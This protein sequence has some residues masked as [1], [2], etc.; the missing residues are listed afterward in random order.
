MGWTENQQLAIDTRDKSL[1]VSAAAGSGKTAI[2][3][4]RIVKIIV[5][6]KVDV[7]K[8]LVVTFTKAAAE[9]MRARLY[10]SL[11][12][13]IKNN[14][15]EYA[16]INKQ[17]SNLPS[18]SISTLHSFCLNITKRYFH[19]IN[20]DPGLGI[21]DDT[22]IAIL[23]DKA[24]EELFEGEYEKED[25]RFFHLLEMFNNRRD[26][27]Q[28]RTIIN[29]MHLFLKNRPFP[30]KWSDHA[31]KNF[32][33]TIEE[34][35]QSLFYKEFMHITEKKLQSAKNQLIIALKIA[36]T[37]EPNE[38]VLAIIDD[39]MSQVNN[40]INALR[41][42]YD[43]FYKCL[44]LSKFATLNFKCEDLDA[45][46]EIVVKRN[47][48]KDIVKKI[49]ESLQYNSP[50][51]MLSDIKD[52]APEISYLMDLVFQYD[53]IFRGLKLEKRLMDFNDIEHYTLQILQTEEVARELRN[54]YKFIFVDE[55]Q[56]SNE[57]QDTILSSMMKEDNVFFVGDVKQSIYRFRMADPTLF[58]EKQ[59]IF[60]QVDEH[61]KETI[62]L[63][64]NFRSRKKIIEFINLVFE[65]IMSKYIGEVDY[66]EE[67]KL[68]L[69]SIQPPLDEQVE[70]SIIY[71]DSDNISCDEV[72]EMN[73][74][75]A[76][77]I[78]IADKIK[79]LLR[80]MVYDQDIKEYRNITYKDIV[81]LLRTTRGWA[82]TYYETLNNEGIPVYAESQIG[83]FDTLEIGLVIQLI[84][85]IDNV[86][87]D[88]PLIGVMRS[89]IFLFTIEEITTIRIYDN[90][91]SIYEAIC[92]Y[93]A[94]QNDNIS[95]KLDEMLSKIRRWKKQCR[96]MPINDFIWKI[97]VDTGYYHYISA[98]PGGV[99]RQANIRILI[100]RAK[101]YSESTIK[102]LFNFIRL[103][104]GMKEMKR[105]LTSAKV[106]GPSENV[107]RVMSIHKSKGL[108]FPV[109][110]IGGL[111]KK[112]NLQDIR[113]PIIA[114][115]DLGIC[116]NYVNL[117]ERRY[118]P[119]IFKTIAKEKLQ[120]ETLSEE[121]RVLYVAMSRARD[122]LYLV[123]SVNNVEQNINK[124][125]K[126]TLSEYDVSTGKNYLDWIM[127]VLLKQ[128]D[129]NDE[130][131]QQLVKLN[132]IKLSEVYETFKNH[133]VQD[134]FNLIYY[135]SLL[136]EK[137]VLDKEIKEKLEW[138]YKYK[139]ASIMPTKATVTE[140][141]NASN[142]HQVNHIKI[143]ETFHS[144]LF[145]EQK[146]IS[147]TERGNTIHFILQHLELNR[148]KKNS[149]ILEAEIN[150]QI[151]R[152]MAQDLLL[153]EEIDGFYAKKITLFIKG[154]LGQRMINAQNIYREKPFNLKSTLN[155]GSKDYILIQGI[156]DCFFLEGDEYILID[157]KSDY[158]GNEEDKLSLIKGYSEQ[159]ALYKRAIEEL[160][161][162]KVKQSYLYL[163]HKNEIVQIGD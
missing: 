21:G 47:K 61:S 91:S 17:I 66:D 32:E 114:H 46:E 143:S 135:W 33:F 64:Q 7:D 115:K 23:K 155:D 13:N 95:I 70:V 9:E 145:L 67:A 131:V 52:M 82:D 4:E 6:D 79:E 25:N 142:G 35:N 154:K 81:I 140:L 132:M 144:P 110:F 83:Y 127:P 123:G 158:Y 60:R 62:A 102:G 2:L 152:M 75:E 31:L 129:A 36:G 120:L 103:I 126:A 72:M 133:Q 55:Y 27:E 118:T 139:N 3:V 63:N 26:E 40:L 48:S 137:E 73:K 99:Q 156:I 1:L 97:V 51:D 53:D 12:A 153:R 146:Q 57:I 113:D 151:A 49:K 104:E 15:E 5:E 93:I 59:K 38:K 100:D 74:I 92:S 34:F 141:K 10:K 106:I 163:F 24:M 37:I 54:H 41:K 116:P 128:Q 50:E 149:H 69:G 90:K 58:L 125:W 65:Q 77:A 86:Y 111:G 134:K 94:N 117:K 109:V 124:N 19:V 87:Q 14:K 44:Y 29:R 160:T 157:Y 11:V 80:S 16:F 98:M 121:M 159:I 101:Q 147:G 78:Y 56:D 122:Y 88:I 42:D 18:A 22:Q 107:V 8:L 96:F 138:E 76:E 150:E 84:K 71:N 161:K 136:E 162:R 105:D 39:E 89:P 148:L 28:I 108:E 30:K 68:Y 85:V 112:M 130:N 45:K 20:L 43:S 119:T